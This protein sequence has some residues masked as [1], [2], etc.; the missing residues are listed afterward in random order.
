MNELII[1]ILVGATIWYWSDTTKAKEIA[2]AAGLDACNKADLQFLDYTV[3]RKHILVRRNQQQRLEIC[4]LY[5]FEF[6]HLG[7]TRYKGRI[8]LTGHQVNQIQLD[9]YRI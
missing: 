2:L 9:A 5:H 6:T 1:A 3:E 8:I 4:R 7:D